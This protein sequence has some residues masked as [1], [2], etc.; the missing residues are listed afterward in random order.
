MAMAAKPSADRGALP[1]GK[2]PLF[3]ELLPGDDYSLIDSGDGQK[4]EQY[5]PYRIVRPEGQAIW[6]RTLDDR[7]WSRV[8]AV[9]TGD[10][11]EEGLGRWHFP[12]APLGETWP[13][14]HDGIDY[15]GRF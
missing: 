2:A 11:D 8:D 4:L 1:R 13:M 9:F 3:L 15:L 10:T 12:A 5:G 14:R 7:A 6:R